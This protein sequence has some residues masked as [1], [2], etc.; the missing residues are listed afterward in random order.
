STDNNLITINYLGNKNL[1]LEPYFVYNSQKTPYNNLNIAMQN[2]SLKN[3]LSLNNR[4]EKDRNSFKFGTNFSNV[5]GI[6][7]FG[8]DFSGN[9][10]ITAEENTIVLDN[11][12]AIDFSDLIESNYT[13][14]ISNTGI[15]ITNLKQGFNDLDPLVQ[16][17]SAGSK[18]GRIEGAIGGTGDGDTAIATGTSQFAGYF[19]DYTT[20]FEKEERLF[21]NFDTSSLGETANVT[22]AKFFFEVKSVTNLDQNNNPC[23]G[24][25]WSYD[26]YSGQNLIGGSL[27]V[28]DYSKGSYDT[29]IDLGVVNNYTVT[30][31]NSR[32][33]NTGFSDIIIRPGFSHTDLC[34]EYNTVW[35]GEALAY[36]RPYLNVT[37]NTVV[38]Y[39]LVY[40]ANGNLIQG[41]GKYFEY[42]GFNHLVKARNSTNDLIA[43]YYYDDEGN[44]LKKF[45]TF[46]ATNNQSTYYMG[47]FIQVRN[48]S[49]VF[50]STFYYANDVLVGEK[51]YDGKTYFYHPDHLGSTQL[52][53]DQNGNVVENTSYDPYGT[54]I[55]DG[56]S[57]YQFTGKE[58]DRETNFEY[59]GARYYY[60]WLAR[61]IQ[62]DPLIQNYYN[63]QSLNRYSYVL[64]NPYR[65]IDPSGH[66]VET[67]L[68]IGFISWDIYD[69]NEN[70]S[71]PWNYLSL[72]LDVGATTVPFVTGG[73]LL[74]KGIEKS[75]DIAKTAEKVSTVDKVGDITNIGGKS[76]SKLDESMSI[77]KFSDLSK[78]AQ[79]AIKKI[80]SGNIKDLREHPFYNTKSQLP[81]KSDTNYYRAYD[82]I[83]K[84]D[85][86][87]I[88]RGSGGETYY[89]SD[90]YKT[91]SKVEPQKEWWRFW[92]K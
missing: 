33:N 56:K 24:F 37:Y 40:D 31:S 92:K 76:L 79:Q 1:V 69:I 30:I 22:N 36:L 15:R 62:P 57:R 43:Q 87:R 61:F 44:R 2:V 26:I 63:P 82:V 20:L 68:D 10:L 45:E 13:I 14:S 38:T 66:F 60:P 28:A 55:Q 16:F 11:I 77:Q 12:I 51:R 71:N 27:D 32:V 72:A 41:F 70:P 46:N 83:S 39:N 67:A 47:G 75:V 8:F 18:D 9:S 86:R 81:M 88:V 59:Y 73:R 84:E 25:G 29:S 7:E 5:E 58:L 23:S 64:N 34:K 89:T 65:Y 78:D 53:T 6:S 90:H 50:N 91:F 35:M 54:V 19:S 48:I 49:G 21:F 3:L 80:D 85:S 74:V 4:L 52:I 17:Y 42:D